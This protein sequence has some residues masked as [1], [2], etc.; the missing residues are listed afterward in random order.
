MW[1]SS[2]GLRSG[3]AVNCQ[4]STVNCQLNTSNPLEIVY[5]NS[6]WSSTKILETPGLLTAIRLVRS[7]DSHSA[8]WERTRI[9]HARTFMVI[10][11][12]WYSNRHIGEDINNFMNRA[13]T[14][15]ASM[16]WFPLCNCQL[17]T[18][19][20]PLLY[21]PYLRLKILWSI[22]DGWNFYY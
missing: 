21:Y 9:P 1:P 14:R 18:V 22:Q 11:R 19:N 8:A 13:D 2:L 4:L 20:C 17:S 5:T 3:Q 15:T 16:I 12:T 6:P 7:A 10:D